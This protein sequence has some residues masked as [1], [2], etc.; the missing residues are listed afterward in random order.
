VLKRVANQLTDVQKMEL[1]PYHIVNDGR[2]LLVQLEQLIAELRQK[3][4][5]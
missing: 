5:V 3:S 4:K 1:T 2:P